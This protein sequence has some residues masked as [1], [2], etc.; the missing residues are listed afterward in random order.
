MKK[1]SIST[2]TIINS[3]G[4]CQLMGE[5]HSILKTVQDH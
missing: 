5:D 1:F 2:E 4:L 3:L